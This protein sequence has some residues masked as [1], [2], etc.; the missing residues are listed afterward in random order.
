MRKYVL[1][2]LVAWL[3]LG[4]ISA[5]RSN[6]E[7]HR[8]LTVTEQVER[9][10]KDLKLTDEQTAKVTTLYTEFEKKMKEA[11]EGAREKMR[12][13]RQKLNKNIEAILTDEQKAAFK[14]RH[15]RKGNGPRGQHPKNK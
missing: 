1:F 7:G 13:E 11:G 4:S 6:N 12:E 2:A 5:Q 14:T 9:L 10:K 15:E 3:S 8:R